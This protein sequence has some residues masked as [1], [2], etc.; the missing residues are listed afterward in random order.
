MAFLAT[1]FTFGESW[2]SLI[3]FELVVVYICGEVLVANLPAKLRDDIR[4][5]CIRMDGTLSTKR[6]SL[7][8]TALAKL[9]WD[10]RIVLL[11]VFAPTTMLIWII[12][13]EVVPVTIGFDA[14]VD[15]RRTAATGDEDLTSTKSSFEKWKT[16]NSNGLSVDEH[17]A[18]LKQVWILLVIGAIVWLATCWFLVRSSYIRQLKEFA[19]RI[20]TRRQEY[21]LYDRAH[22]EEWKD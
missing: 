3:V 21:S 4:L 10:I 11:L 6:Q 7:E 19:N 1:L 20:Q 9:R 12:D 22:S 15:I 2:L 16:S 8:K 5:N 14:L 13:R 18:L 17:K